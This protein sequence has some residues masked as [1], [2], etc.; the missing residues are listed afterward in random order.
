[1]RSI[2]A[3]AALAAPVILA[4]V[5][6]C[7]N[8]PDLP[9]AKTICMEAPQGS[10]QEAEYVRRKAAE[11]SREHGFRIVDSACD[12]AVKYTPFG[13]FQGESAVHHG[14]WISRSGYW[15]QEGIVSLNQGTKTILQDYPVN[16]RGY[17]SKQELLDALAW[18][19]VGPVTWHFQS[20]P[21]KS[22][23]PKP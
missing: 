18:Q 12:V 20:E 11:Y 5:T 6:G 22:K 13:A 4:A 2:R 14:F 9:I 21:S 8:R 15:S 19:V 3:C 7:A 16:L 10:P 23:T 17:S 1:M